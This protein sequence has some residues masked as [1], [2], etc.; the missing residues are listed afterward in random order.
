[1]LGQ[2]APLHHPTLMFPIHPFDGPSTLLHPRTTETSTRFIVMALIFGLSLLGILLPRLA[3]LSP[4]LTLMPHSCLL[5][6]HLEEVS[7][8]PHPL[9]RLLCRKA[10]WHRSAHPLMFSGLLLTLS[11]A[12]FSPQPLSTSC[13][14]PLIV[15]R[16]LKSSSILT[17][18]AGPA[19]S[20]KYS[21]LSDL[22]IY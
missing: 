3:S 13:K 11:K 17:S 15:S 21:L 12:S 2:L 9:H 7:L 22:Q 6:R 5:P 19:L 14:M 1:M 10:L 18:A 8:S 16:I 20:C 4:Y